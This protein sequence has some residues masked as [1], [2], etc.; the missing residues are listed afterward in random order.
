MYIDLKN[1][2]IDAKID[3]WAC[4]IEY[5]NK[6]A[7]KVFLYSNDPY[8]FGN[9]FIGYY[10][11]EK[12]TIRPLYYNSMIDYRGKEPTERQQ[13]KIKRLCKKLLRYNGII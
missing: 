9:K 1:N 8:C 12:E 6:D 5:I 2:C 10:I 4:T 13:E 3:Q 7:V 11:P